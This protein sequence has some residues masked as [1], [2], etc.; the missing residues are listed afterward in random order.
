MFAALLPI[1]LPIIVQLIGLVIKH[2]VKDEALTR[3][4][5]KFAELA[6][7]GNIQGIIERQK[8][9]KRLGANE[10]KWQQIEAEEKAKGIKR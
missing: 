6:R 4:F 7:K 9:E 3:E 1:V 10:K 8:A 2:F 5:E